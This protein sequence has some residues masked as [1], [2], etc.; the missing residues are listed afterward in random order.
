MEGGREGERERAR[1]SEGERA[2]ARVSE[3]DLRMPGLSAMS[4]GLFDRENEEDGLSLVVGAVEVEAV[5][6][7]AAL[8]LPISPPE[9]AELG[10]DVCPL[11][12]FVGVYL[13]VFTVTY[14]YIYVYIYTYIH[15]YVCIHTY[16][17]I[18]IHT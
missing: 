8:D 13:F 15:T 4:S 3:R 14:I 11:R 6:A 7:A 18:S 12:V 5:E 1:E 10:T 17:Y 9:V 16:I 2:R